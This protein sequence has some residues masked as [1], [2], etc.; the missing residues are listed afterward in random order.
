MPQIVAC[1]NWALANVRRLATE[2]GLR[3]WHKLWTYFW[4][5]CSWH[6]TTRAAHRTGRKVSQ[7]GHGEDDRKSEYVHHMSL[8]SISLFSPHLTFVQMT[9]KIM[10]GL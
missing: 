4:V 10:G 5:R 2:L 1:D 8:L 7:G 3:Q 6:E 9:I